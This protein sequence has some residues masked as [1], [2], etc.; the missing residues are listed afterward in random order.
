MLVAYWRYKG[1]IFVVKTFVSLIA[2]DGVGVYPRSYINKLKDKGKAL[3]NI[4]VMLKRQRYS[5]SKQCEDLIAGGVAQVPNALMTQVAHLIA[6]A[7]RSLL[8][9]I[10]VDATSEQVALSLPSSNHIK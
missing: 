3:N 10:G 8:L 1:N 7:R 5:G 6:T 4:T 2:P 9:E